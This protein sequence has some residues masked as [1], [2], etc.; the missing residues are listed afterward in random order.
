M[1]FRR[2]CIN[3]ANINVLINMLW[4][5]SINYYYRYAIHYTHFK[6]KITKPYEAGTYCVILIEWKKNSDIQTSIKR[7]KLLNWNKKKQQVVRITCVKQTFERI[8]LYG[9]NDFWSHSQIHSFSMIQFNF[10]LL[11]L[12]FAQSIF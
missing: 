5:M 3:C 11:F 9:I 2:P 8:A 10:M 12:N 7:N 4:Y 1:N 6:K